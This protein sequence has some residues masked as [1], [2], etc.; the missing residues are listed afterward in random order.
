[1][2]SVFLCTIIVRRGTDYASM[3]AIIIIKVFLYPQLPLLAGPSIPDC[4]NKMGRVGEKVDVSPIITIM[5]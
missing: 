5:D 4:L 2:I 3:F 1:M